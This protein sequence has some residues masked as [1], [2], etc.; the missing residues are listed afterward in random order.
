MSRPVFSALAFAVT[1]GA[2][3]IL[4][5]PGI[6]EASPSPAAPDG[7]ITWFSGYTYPDT[8]AGN[9]AC[10]AMGQ[11]ERAHSNVWNYSC[12]LGNP[13]AGVWNLWLSNLT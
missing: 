1:L 2:G 9:S 11:Y 10:V 12:V 5:S 3:V 7:V 8:S 4:A 13:D 6:A